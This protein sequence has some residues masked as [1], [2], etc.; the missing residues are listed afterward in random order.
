MVSHHLA[1]FIGHRECG[2]ADIMF[3][4]V[5]EPDSTCFCLN[6]SYCLSLSSAHGLKANAYSVNKFHIGHTHLKEK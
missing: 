1:K 6:M 2:S 5:A 4:V 3:L